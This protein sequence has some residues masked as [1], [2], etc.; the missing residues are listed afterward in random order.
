MA[1]EAD[2]YNVDE[3]ARLLGVSPPASEPA[4]TPSASSEPLCE[5][6]SEARTEA[7]GLLAETDHREGR[8][9][10]NEGEQRALREALQRERE[11]ADRVRAALEAESPRRAPA[12]AR[13]P[14]TR[15][16]GG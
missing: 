5:D 10:T 16:L 1:R 8:P 6:V 12:E 14:G 7:Q 3:T 2:Y 9:E 11:R 13:S 4:S 15:L